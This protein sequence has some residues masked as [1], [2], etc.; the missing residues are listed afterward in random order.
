MWEWFNVSLP[1]KLSNMVDYFDV[2]VGE[3]IPELPNVTYLTVT[4]SAWSGHSYAA[5]LARLIARCVNLEELHIV[6]NRDHEKV[7]SSRTKKT[8]KCASSL[9]NSALKYYVFQIC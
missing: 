5:S 6:V 2:L 1:K 4:I 8:V 3:E 9:H 7:S